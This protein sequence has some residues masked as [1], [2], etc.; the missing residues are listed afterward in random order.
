MITILYWNK[1]RV[2]FCM[3]H[4]ISLTFA[5]LIQVKQDLLFYN[6]HFCFLSVSY[7]TLYFFSIHVSS[8]TSDVDELFQ[9]S[10]ILDLH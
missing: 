3:Y 5:E 6:I 7:I 1:L 9:M 8:H 10:E 2:S 4:V